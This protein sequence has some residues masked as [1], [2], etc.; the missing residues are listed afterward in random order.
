M[1]WSIAWWMAGH[2]V[3]VSLPGVIVGQAWE[4]PGQR[5][6]FVAFAPL[7]PRRFRGADLTVGQ[8]CQIAPRMA[9]NHRNARM[10][11][12]ANHDIK[13]GLPSPQG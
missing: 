4:R 9:H 3:A 10:A 6:E 2:P 12:A 7:R 1:S 11:R 5:G 8:K 13:G